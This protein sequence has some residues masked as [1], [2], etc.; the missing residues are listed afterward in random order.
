MPRGGQESTSSKAINTD[1]TNSLSN[2]C[3]NA[4]RNYSP[5]SIHRM[6][7]CDNK[8]RNQQTDTNDL[9][10]IDGLQSYNSVCEPTPIT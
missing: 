4:I 9:S 5:M 3:N 10:P 1:F 8:S 2:F 6:S 7:T